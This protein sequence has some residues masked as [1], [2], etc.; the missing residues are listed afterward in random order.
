[1]LNNVLIVDR[2]RIGKSVHS[3][4]SNRFVTMMDF[5]AVDNY[6]GTF[7]I[8]KNRFTGDTGTVGRITVDSIL[9]RE[10]ANGNSQD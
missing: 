2:G 4:F 9:E 7:T 10:E 1:M 8:V 5:I 6:D 3:D